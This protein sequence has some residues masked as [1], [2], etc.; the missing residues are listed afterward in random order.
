MLNL[1]RQLKKTRKT[2]CLNKQ[3]VFQQIY[4]TFFVLRVNTIKQYL[5]IVLYKHMF[6][7]ETYYRFVMFTHCFL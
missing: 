4:V 3:L 5:L 1:K 2:N 6:C 7:R